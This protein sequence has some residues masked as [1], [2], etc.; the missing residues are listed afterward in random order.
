MPGKTKNEAITVDGSKRSLSWPIRAWICE[1]LMARTWRC[2]EGWADV[3]SVCRLVP[4][5]RRRVDHAGFEP[6]FAE[7]AEQRLA[8][9]RVMI[10]AACLVCLHGA[11][12]PVGISLD[13]EDP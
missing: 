2:P 1:G 4:E 13:L 9:V 7:I 6:S 3:K 8:C 12:V 5:D 11:P 10:L